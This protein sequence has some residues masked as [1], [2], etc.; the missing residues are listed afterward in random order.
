MKKIVVFLLL[1]YSFHSG[2]SQD[3]TS[4]DNVY[5]PTL[6][7]EARELY[8][9]GT[10]ACE[11]KKYTI[12]IQKF[13]KVILIDP[14]FTDSYDNLA[15]CFRRTNQLDSAIFY[16]NKSLKLYPKNRLALNNLGV[17]Y[18]DNNQ[19]D[20]AEEIYKKSLGLNPLNIET[21]EA[22][23]GYNGEPYYGLCRTYFYQKKY[24]LAIVNGNQAYELWKVKLPLYASDALYIVGLSYL[25]K[26][27]REKGLIA[28]KKSSSLGNL[29]A[30]EV[31]KEL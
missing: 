2:Y 21:D 13:K 31:L 11:N 25:N 9:E 4:E 15:V 8:N 1:I 18:I 19:F 20:K 29:N 16:Y 12:A 17:A 6:I 22:E 14:K 26:G 30:K 10:I 5:N 28:L 3:R 27:D 7:P 23:I 24:E